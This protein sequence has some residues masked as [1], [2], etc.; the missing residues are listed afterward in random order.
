MTKV[1]VQCVEYCGMLLNDCAGKSFIISLIAREGQDMHKITAALVILICLSA[2]L[3]CSRKEAPAPARTARVSATK[4]FTTYFGPA[5]TTD[6]GICYAFVIYFP[7]AKELE[8][9]TPFPFFSFD[10]ASL[11]KIALQ[12]MLSGMDEKS[13]AGEFLQ[14]FP[15]GSRLLS[16]SEREGTVSADFSKELREVADNPSR[17]RALFNA[18]TLTLLQF[19]GV[20]GVRIHCEGREL[21][22]AATRLP[23]EAAVVAQPS[24]PRLLSVIAMKQGASTPVLEVDALFDRPVDIKEFQFLENDGTL[25]TG[26]VFHSM[27][28]MAA[29]LKPKEPGKLAQGTKIRARYRVVDKMGRSAAGESSFALEVKLHQD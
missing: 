4:A 2:F 21:F 28:D 14:L 5:P 3:G 13:Y 22:P 20:T 10:E 11:K 9:V 18:L 17:S 25:L 16:V 23:V 1:R 26:E 27:F 12:R 29:V 8:K 6:K 19:S 7:R 24:A 15:K